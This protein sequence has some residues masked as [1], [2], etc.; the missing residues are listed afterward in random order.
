MVSK[1]RF[2]ELSPHIRMVWLGFSM[3]TMIIYLNCLLFDSTLDLG[4]WFDVLVLKWLIMPSVSAL[5]S[6]VTLTGAI[7][8]RSPYPYT[9]MNRLATALFGGVS[10]GFVLSVICQFYWGLT[11]WFMHYG[12]NR[13]GGVMEAAVLYHPFYYAM[14][15]LYILAMIRHLISRREIGILVCG[16]I[17]WLACVPFYH[18]AYYDR[19]YFWQVPLGVHYGLVIWTGITLVSLATLI[20]VFGLIR[21]ERYLSVLSSEVVR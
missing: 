10:L 20:S 1:R 18:G 17:V 14:V 7:C 4:Q 21:I 12:G 6:S 9:A 11:L 16:V 13:L 5:V 8:L 19:G 15:M 2:R 3:Q